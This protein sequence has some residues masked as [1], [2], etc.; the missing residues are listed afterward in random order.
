[1]FFRKLFKIFFSEVSAAQ[2]VISAVLG[3][4]LGFMPGI[5]QAFGLVV[6]LLILLFILNTNLTLAF[7]VG[8]AAKLVA[9]VA[10]PAVFAI[11]RIFLDGP[12]QSIFTGLINAPIF[13]LFGF[14]Y[15]FTTGGLFVGL[16]FGAV[17]GFV[18]VKMVFGLRTK[19]AS[20]EANSQAF[21]DLQKRLWVR[22]LFFCL[23]G[24]LPKDGFQDLLNKK[25][26]VIRI[27]GVVTALAFVALLFAVV[28]FANGPLAASIIK[29]SLEKANGAT[30]DIKSLDLRLDESRIDIT[31]LAMADPNALETD[32]FR[33]E[34][35]TIDIRASDL[36]RKRV[37]LEKVEITAASNGLKRAKPGVIV[38][39]KQEVEQSNE[40]SASTEADGGKNLDGYLNNAKEWKQRL[41]QAKKWLD[42]LSGVATDENKKQAAEVIDTKAA[43]TPEKQLDAWLDQQIKTQGYGNVKANHLVQGAPLLQIE[44]LIA[45]K[46]TTIAIDETLTLRGSNL[47]THPH[48]VAGAANITVKSSKKSIFMDLAMAGVSAAGGDNRLKLNLSGLP[49]DKIAGQLSGSKPPLLSGGTFAVDIDGII[50]NRGGAYLN[51]PLDVTLRDTTLTISGQ[52]SVPVKQFILPL[53]VR[54]PLDNPGIIVDDKQ[55]QKSIAKAGKSII[56]DRLK[57]ELDKKLKGKAGGLLDKLGGSGGGFKLP[58]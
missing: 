43:I 52:G 38:G 27:S 46:I 30:V 33:S 4:M 24:G 26:P 12:T 2:L 39:P 56:K 5:S 7:L 41:A 14:E 54:G 18:L 49:T 31:G 45:D 35:I 40:S 25:P 22:A 57:K 3:A 8:L 13:A 6:L 55:L 17:V 21:A 32:L 15:Y 44:R 9:W 28:Q 58:F 29:N 37:N 20:M 16:V 50:Q 51:L 47:S 48:L 11:G 34:K 10:A 53:T 36:L 19:L 23:S 42:K 1:M